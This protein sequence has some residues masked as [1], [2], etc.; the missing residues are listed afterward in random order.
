MDVGEEDKGSTAGQVA[1]EA[2]EIPGNEVVVEAATCGSHF[3]SSS[4]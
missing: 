3:F 1:A 2:V 4:E